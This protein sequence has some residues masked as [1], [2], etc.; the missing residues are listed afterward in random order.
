[1]Q[2]DNFHS[3]PESVKAFQKDR[4]VTTIKRGDGIIRT[5]FNIPGSYKGYNGEF[6][7]MQEPNSLINDR[8]FQPYLAPLL[9]NF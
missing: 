1:M 7:F 9:K 4:Y 5:Q 8:F 6:Q 3:F 2:E